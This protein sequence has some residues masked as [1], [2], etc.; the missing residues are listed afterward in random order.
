MK[1]FGVTLTRLL[2]STLAEAALLTFGAGL[3]HAQKNE[4]MWLVPG[5]SPGL[6]LY[7]RTDPPFLFHTDQW[8]AIVFYRNPDCV[9]G[10]F[11]LLQFPHP[12]AFACDLTVSGFELREKGQTVEV[13]PRQAVSSGLAV[14]VWFVDWPTLQPFLIDN[15]LTKSE[16]ES[17]NP[18]KGQAGSYHEIL[19]P[20]APPGVPGGAEVPHLTITASGVLPDGRSFRCELI[21][22]GPGELRHVGILIR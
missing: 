4:V 7:T 8:A 12:G 22:G 13:A 11:N 21:A 20:F 14:P 5:D 1:P 3:V 16:L 17:L 18:L 6:P 10:D 19:H 2:A 9:P 15:V